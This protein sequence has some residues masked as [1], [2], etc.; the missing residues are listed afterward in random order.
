MSP[1]EAALASTEEVV[2]SYNI[3]TSQQPAAGTMDYYLLRALLVGQAYLLRLQ[4]LSLDNDVAATERVYRLGVSHFSKLAVP[5][6]AEVEKEKVPE[7]VV[8][9][10]GVPA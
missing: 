10:L 6:P 8:L 7:G 4:A 5:P 9:P 2:S 1:L 3:G